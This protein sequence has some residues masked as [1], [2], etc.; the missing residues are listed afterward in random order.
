[1]HGHTKL[2]IHSKF[3]E[4]RFARRNIMIVVMIR[5]TE[6]AMVVMMGAVL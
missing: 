6:V 1:M 2:E 5:R 4:V 3:I